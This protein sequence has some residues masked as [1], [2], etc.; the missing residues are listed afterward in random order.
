M[1]LSHCFKAPLLGLRTAPGTDP[2]PDSHPY[3]SRPGSCNGSRQFPLSPPRFA[4]IAQPPL[5]GAL[6]FFR[7]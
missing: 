2:G 6:P 4:A 5:Y 1:T 7:Q 3:V